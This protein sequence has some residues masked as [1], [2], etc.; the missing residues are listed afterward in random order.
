MERLKRK[1][2]GSYFYN[3]SVIH[4]KI[5]EVIESLTGGGNNNEM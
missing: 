4:K 2:D 5:D 1:L 3:T